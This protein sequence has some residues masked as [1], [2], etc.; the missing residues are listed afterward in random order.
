MFFIGIFVFLTGHDGQVYRCNF[1]LFDYLFWVL[2]TILK[3][4]FCFFSQL[5]QYV[6]MYVC[7]YSSLIKVSCQLREETRVFLVIGPLR[8]LLC[9]S[10]TLYT[11][12]LSLFTQS[13][14]PN[15]FRGTA[16]T[17]LCFVFFDVFLKKNWEKFDLT[18]D[19]YYII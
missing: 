3:L 19:L 16:C 2:K 18:N 4:L 5:I 13:A 14:D 9:I 10:D 8:F 12:Y 15:T 17:S 11:F 1:S 6:Y 7:M